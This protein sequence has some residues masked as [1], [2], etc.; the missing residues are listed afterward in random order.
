MSKVTVQDIEAVDDYWGPTFRSIL[1]GNNSKAISEQLDQRIRS[2][3]KEIERICNLYYQG[4]IESIQELLQVRTQAKQLHDEIHSLDTSLHQMSASLIQQGNE[5]VRARQIESNLASAIE[6]LK[7][8]LPA[9]ECYLKFTQQTSNKQYYQ[10]LRTLETLETEHLAH[11]QNYRFATQMRQAIPVIKENIRRSAES[12]FREFL[13]NI[14]KFSPRIGEVAIKHIK[15]LQKRDINA[16]IEEHKQQ[17]SNGSGG[18]DDDGGNVSAQDLID[19]SPI[20]RCLHIYMVL[21]QREYF[22]KDYRQQRRDQAKLVLQPPPN[23]H[24]NLEAYKTYICAIVGFFVVE[25]HVKNTAGDVVTST[26][27]EDLWST[28]LTKFVNEIS[29]SSSSC[30]D[31][32]ILLRIKNLIMLSIN[33]FKCYGYTVNIL[34]E[35]LHNMRDHYNE[36]LLQRWVHVFRD[37]LDKEQFLPMIV[38]NTEEYESIIERFPFHSEQLENAPFPKKFPFSRMVPEVYHQ[39]KEFMYACMKFAEE[40]TLSPN[41]VAAMV[42]KAANLLLTR[43]FSGCLSVV[44]RQP[45]ITLTQLIQ[46]IVDTQYLD[47]AGP[48][49]DE[50]VCHMTNTERSISQTPSAMFH[51]ARQDAE[52]QVAVRICSKVD[53]FFELSAY[54]WLLVEPPGIASAFITDMISYLKSTFDSFSH[55]LTHIAQAG[56]RRTCEHI[57]D[58]IYSILYDEE[59][60]QISTGALTQIN[61]DLMQ[62]EF[63]AA[64]EPVPGLREGE[65][66]KY[67]LR[68]RQLLDLLILEEWST[69]LHDYGKQDNRYHLVQ[70]QS[71]IVI[72]EKIREADKK[73]IFSL[74]RKNDKKKL[75]ETVLKQLKHLADRQS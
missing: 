19:F 38:E 51:V 28:S 66:T 17:A 56:C 65:L 35:L 62:C 69:Y 21:G 61:L 7:S 64:S 22:E 63:F 72:L 45:S 68:N 26:Y 5:L 48:F 36:V 49:L 11:L 70:P 24:D 9:L 4:F 40:L 29:M 52:K 32:N 71:I 18:G 1:E 10:S 57:A 31:P 53:E 16:I 12:D 39:A 23:M 41:E 74:V 50:F 13:E 14:R 6:A 27:L 42:R 55:K 15:Q 58:K 67:F 75:L 73:P 2:H 54:D 30:T 8:C 60:K 44:F 59:V 25:D 3:D 20:Y 46:I 47:K 37:I 43:S 33:T 34:W